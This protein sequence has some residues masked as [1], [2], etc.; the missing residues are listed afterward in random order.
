MVKMS[1]CKVADKITNRQSK[2]MAADGE[3]DGGSRV[4][5]SDGGQGLVRRVKADVITATDRS[6]QLPARKYTFL[7]SN[8]TVLGFGSA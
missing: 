3:G 6:Y 8:W 4:L 5:G 2:N 1:K 7:Q